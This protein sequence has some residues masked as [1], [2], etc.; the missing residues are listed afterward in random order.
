M[1]VHLEILFALQFVIEST[2]KIWKTVH[3]TKTVL[4]DAHAI[5]ILAKWQRLLPLFHQPLQ[6]YSTFIPFFD[7][8]KRVETFIERFLQKVSA[9]SQIWGKKIFVFTAF[10]GKSVCWFKPKNV[11]GPN[12]MKIMRSLVRWKNISLIYT[13]YKKSSNNY[14][15]VKLFFNT[16]IV[17]K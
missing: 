6:W 3:V 2:N 14:F 7:V 8:S 9:S 10:L 1:C 5:A 15:V 11:Q 16:R 13:F 17:P 12:E 4:V